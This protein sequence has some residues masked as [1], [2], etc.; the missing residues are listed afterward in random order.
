MKL[1]YLAIYSVPDSQSTPTRLV[2][3]EELSSTFNIFQRG[4]VREQLVFAT[5]TFSQ[6]T[7]AGTRQALKMNDLPFRLYI[8]TRQD[9]LSGCIVADEEYP[10]RVAFAFVAQVMDDLKTKYGEKLSDFKEDT[11][12]SSPQ[13]QADFTKY[14]DPQEADKI[15]KIQKNLDEVKEI[16]QQNIEEVLARGETLDSLMV[17]S[18]DLSKTSITFYQTA[19]KN[20][21]CCQLY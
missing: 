14:Q 7:A 10:Q 18:G 5:R 13:L 1:L 21:Q 20:N 8:H 15:L 12:L 9:N 16:M 11:D 2:A 17:K 6:R 19:K 3:C 4:P